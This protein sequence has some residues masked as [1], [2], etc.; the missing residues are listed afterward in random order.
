M[1]RV[2]GRG[3]LSMT[4]GPRG[5]AAREG[6]GRRRLLI[7]ALVVVVVGCAGRAAPPRA[8]LAI[9]C[10]VPGALVV[11]DDTPLG[12]VAEWA[13]P[14]RWIR[15]GFHRVEVRHPDH[16]PHYAEISPK[17]GEQTTVTAVLRPILD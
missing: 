8:R 1:A 16:H 17:A 10:P 12:G 9:V 5:E 15:A 6:G 3:D 7:A 2:I 4:G 14:G 11:I 13:P